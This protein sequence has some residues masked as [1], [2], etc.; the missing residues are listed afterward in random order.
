M[1]DADL[2]AHAPT[3]LR[4]LCKEVRRLQGELHQPMGYIPML[5]GQYPGT[6]NIPGSRWVDKSRF[7]AGKLFLRGHRSYIGPTNG[8]FTAD[9]S[10]G[11][12]TLYELCPNSLAVR[13]D[14]HRGLP[15]DRNRA[16]GISMLG[17]FV[18]HYTK[19]SNI[20][21]WIVLRS[22]FRALGRMDGHLPRLVFLPLVDE[23]DVTAGRNSER[24]AAGEWLRCR[25][26]HAPTPARSRCT[27]RSAPATGRRS[28][29]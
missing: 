21:D 1:P 17:S 8:R 5:T 14:I 23:G 4:E 13:S 22:L 18:S 12:E 16:R 11:L 20:V 28:P 15:P 19:R 7:T 29:T 2:F 26:A 25:G 3:A 9:L 27:T 10:M 6:A 24:V